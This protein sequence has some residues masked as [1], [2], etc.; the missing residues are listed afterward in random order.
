[1]ETKMNLAEIKKRH[2]YHNVYARY[3]KTATLKAHADR[4][5]LIAWLER[6][7]PYVRAESA[8]DGEYRDEA[9]T[10]LHEIRGKK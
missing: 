4:A 8:S 9:S 6:A 5:Q 1:M 2:D 3:D 10:L 7:M